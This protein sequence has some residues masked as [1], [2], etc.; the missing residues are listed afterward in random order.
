MGWKDVT[1]RRAVRLA[2]AEADRLGREAF[3]E[4]YGYGK[5][6]EFILVD[7]SKRYDS[8]AILAVAHR[9]EFPDE[10]PLANTMFSGGRAGAA[11][12]LAKLGF[13]IE[14]L[15]RRDADWDQSE[16]KVT[17]A[18]Y[19]YMLQRELKQQSYNKREHNES[20]RKLLRNRSK[21][22]VELKHQNI[23]AILQEI[24]LPFIEGYKPRGNYQLLLKAEVVDYIERHPDLFDQAPASAPPSLP[25][26]DI[27]VP[28]LHPWVASRLLK[29][30]RGS[31]STSPVETRTTASLD[32]Q[33]KSG[34]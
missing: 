14:G 13:T 10:G 3:L 18:D 23:S 22:S 11:G 28:P 26:K 2:M 6:R 25:T 12:H 31:R 33:V 27:F 17:V 1:S 34:S 30:V 8:K 7:G 32:E 9:F 19:F 5:A 16:V 15:P 4:R 24:G 20:L 21:G 29:L